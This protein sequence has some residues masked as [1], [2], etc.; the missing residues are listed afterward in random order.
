MEG[1]KLSNYVGY[2]N[3]SG[4]SAWPLDRL[5]YCDGCP[6]NGTQLTIHHVGVGIL[7]HLFQCHCL[8]RQPT[9]WRNMIHK[10]LVTSPLLEGNPSRSKKRGRSATPKCPKP[11]MAPPATSLAEMR[12]REVRF[13]TASHSKA[14]KKGKRQAA[15]AASA[16]PTEGRTR[17]EDA[18]VTPASL[19]RYTQAWQSVQHL[20]FRSPSALKPF[21]TIDANLAKHLEE[22]FMDG[23]DLSAAQYVIAATFFFSPAIKAGGMQKLPRVKQSLQG[24]RRLAPPQ[25]RLP[26]P[27]E[28]VAAL[29]LWGCRNNFKPMAMRMILNFVLYLR[30]TEA[31]HLRC[32]DLVPPPPGQR[33]YR[34]WTVVLHP[35]EVGH[36]SKT[37]EFDE[38]LELDL[39][40]HRKIGEAVFKVQNVANR[41][42]DEPLFNHSLRD[43]GFCKGASTA[44][45]GT[46]APVSSASRGGLTRLQSGPA[47]P[48]CHPASGPL[49]QPSQCKKI[50]EGRKACS[51][52][53]RAF[54]RDAKTGRRGC[55]RPHSFLCV[56]ALSKSLPDPPA[57]LEVFSG[58]HV[59]ATAVVQKNGWPVLF[60]DLKLGAD[61]DLCRAE[62]RHK[63]VGWLRAGRLRGMH[64]GTPCHTFSRARDRRPGPPP[65]RS[66]DHPLGLPHLQPG[67]AHK[68]MINNI[69]MRFS[70]QCMRLCLALKIP[71]TLENPRTSRLWICPPIAHVL[72]RRHVQVWHC[73]FCMFGTPWKKPTSFAGVWVVL[74]RLDSFQ[75]HGSRRQ[76]DQS[77]RPHVPLAGQSPDGRFMTAIAE[78]Y[79]ARLCQ[80]LAVC[81]QDW[82]TQ[83]I[84]SNF[85]KYV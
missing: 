3:K 45:I 47:R 1:P 12:S 15:R 54:S 81:F 83:V 65:L 78:P 85:S 73:D 6:V 41:D 68:V 77:G 71:M 9:S 63:I 74:D 52:L 42:P 58:S 22:M 37:L 43:L 23:E 55:Q 67:D 82:E 44:V 34:C 24:W 21:S 64:H 66:E 38:T 26:V 53:C 30:P 62:N 35:L 59:L 39:E 84:A 60:W 56:P 76:C 57:F 29:V 79:P 70:A 11:Q 32:R 48:C 31:L 51:T 13:R 10:T 8:R 46:S 7:P 50:P 27:F 40:Y 14:T 72:R 18:A 49:A 61:Y 80:V 25:S 4:R 20:V 28:V 17:L 16:P 33:K 36:S 19:R 2:V 5:L 75:C 69:L